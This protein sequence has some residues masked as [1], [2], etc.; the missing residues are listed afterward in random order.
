MS[1][2]VVTSE[3]Q[4]DNLANVATTGNYNDL[5]NKPSIATTTA[6]GLMSFE[7]KKA[8]NAVSN[9]INIGEYQNMQAVWDACKQVAL[10]NPEIAIIKYSVKAGVTYNSGVVFQSFNYNDALV[11]QY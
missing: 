10:T 6:N 8:I 5:K 11:T 9:I 4:A 2:K 1:K 3:I 7:D